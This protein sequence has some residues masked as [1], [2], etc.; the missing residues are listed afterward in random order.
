MD[1][2]MSKPLQ[3][4]GEITFSTVPRWRC[5]GYKHISSNDHPVIEFANITRCDSSAV[6]LLLAWLRDA[7]E[8]GKVVHFA[9]LPQ[10][11]MDV[12]EVYGVLK[13]V[14]TLSGG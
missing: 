2:A 12:A 10:Q 7:K 5:S 4:S 13:A 3:I 11:L 9:H 14:P 1:L 8:K 6:A